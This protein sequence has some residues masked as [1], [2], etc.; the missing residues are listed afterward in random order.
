VTKVYNL[1]AIPISTTQLDYPVDI[2][3]TLCQQERR[4]N[5]KGVIKSNLGG[6]QSDNII[7][8]DS[9]FFFLQDIEKICQEVAKDVLKINKSVF[10]N[11]AWININQKDNLNQVHTHPNNILSGV[12]YVKT[13]EKCGNI[14]FRHPGF[15]MM[16]RDWEDIVS[17]S[18]HN[19]YN[20][21]TWWL[22]AKANTLY[23]FPSWIKHLVGPN[24][25]DEERISMSFN[26]A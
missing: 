7:Y 26:F 12:Y 14:I 8:P 23:I 1:F 25:S 22:P 15:D 21:D 4:K 20:S 2:I 17:D 18:D 11:N 3:E 9:P 19:V 13:P 5:S 6:W 10:L 24:M 16:E